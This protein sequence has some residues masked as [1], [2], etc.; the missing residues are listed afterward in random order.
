MTTASRAPCFLLTVV[1]V[2]VPL[3][4]ACKKQ[5]MVTADS[6]NALLDSAGKAV[7][8]AHVEATSNARCEGDADCVESPTARCT[9]GCG[10]YAVHARVTRSF[11]VAV[12]KVDDGTCKRWDDDGCATIAPRSMPSCPSYV[13]RCKNHACEMV[14]RRAP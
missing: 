12:K 14:D 11:E 10:G 7:E 9:T 1:A 4:V 3:G 6:C 5:S 2:L 13:P 8:K